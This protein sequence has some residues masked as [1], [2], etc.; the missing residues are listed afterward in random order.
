[1]K[2]SRNKPNVFESDVKYVA[3]HDARETCSEQQLQN[4]KRASLYSQ[5][6]RKMLLEYPS[7]MF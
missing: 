6:Y 7:R 2:Y 4:S 5:I 1:M 3:L